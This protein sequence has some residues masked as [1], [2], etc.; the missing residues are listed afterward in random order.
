MSL[1]SDMVSFLKTNAEIKKLNFQF[2]THKIYPAGYITDVANLIDKELIDIDRKISWSG[3]SYFYDTNRL[4]V[5]W[6]FDIK[7][8]ISNLYSFMNALMRF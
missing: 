4:A 7:M 8:I 2:M 1:E 3:A 5:E 6:G